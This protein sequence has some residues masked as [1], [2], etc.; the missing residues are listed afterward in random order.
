VK[1]IDRKLVRD[2]W[3]LKSQVVTVALVVASALSGF[4]GSFATYYSLVDA[5]EAFYE[6]ARFG[7][8][9]SDIERAPR[10]IERRILDISGVSDAETTVVFDV[11]LD[12][13]SVAEPIVGRMIGFDEANPPRLNQ[14]VIR[15]GRAP[16]RGQ[17]AEVVVSEG[18][19]TTRHLSPGQT[20]TALINGRKETL[21]IVGVGLSPEY[22]YASRG[23]AFPDDRSFGVCWIGRERLAAAYNMEGAFNHVTVRLAPGASERGAIDALDRLLEPYGGIGA[24]GRDEQ[25]SHRILGQEIDQWKVTGTLIPTIFLAVAAF[26]LNVVLNRQVA[27]QREQ[28]AALKALGYGNGALA[29]HYFLQVVLIVFIGTLIGIVVGAWFGEAVTGLYARFFH[30]PSYSFVIPLW[31]VLT[32]TAVTLFAAVAGALGAVRKAVRLAPA[33]AMRPPFPG[34]YR[35]TLMERLRLG[36]LLTPA[37]RMTMRTMERRPWRAL[38]TTFGIASAMAIIISGM[39]W[40][41]ALDYMIGV[42]FEAAQRADADIVLVDALGPRAEHEVARMPGVMLAEGSR[43]VPVRLVAGHHFYRTAVQGLAA[44]GDLRRLLNEALDRISLPSEGILLTDRL[45]ERLEVRVGDN[46]QV[47]ALAGERHKRLVP[48]VGVVRDLI[49]LSAYMDLDALN[50]L[51]GEGDLLSAV[52]V[53]L[54]ASQSDALFRQLKTF[55][56]VAIAAS[57]TAMLANFRETSARNVLFFTSILTA[58][59]AVIAIGVVYN[60]ARIALQERSW[61]LAS[62]RVLG[63]TRGEVSSFLLGEL[64]FE[65]LAAIPLGCVLGYLLSWTIVRMSHHDLIAIPII[66]APRT[67]AFAALAIVVAGA[68]SALIVRRRIDRLDLV[69]VLKTRE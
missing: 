41:D 29:G 35:R 59:A 51:M 11:T 46:V 47:E 63:F 22:I 33:E 60:N 8:A 2:L 18:F 49:G 16:E 62:L 15:R 34:V 14:L 43:D 53:R 48:V 4:V 25:L 69:G 24:Y 3:Q 66:V 42:Q 64:A 7:D 68:A 31:I 19:A 28:I 9:F 39:F 45:A 58:F 32:A 38:L 13:P 36:H 44:D 12:V 37:M 52:S 57:K 21:S 5:R 10:E 20:I 23:G 30:F 55:P 67:Y 26:L 61:E 6:S 65:L 27:T 1:A 17:V 50:R 56:R 40:R 54:D